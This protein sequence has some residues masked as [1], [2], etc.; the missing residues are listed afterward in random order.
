MVNR[1][2]YI[3]VIY[4]CMIGSACVA[5]S[6]DIT[7]ELPEALRFKDEIKKE[8]GLAV[9]R[10]EPFCLKVVVSGDQQVSGDVKI[11][12]IDKFRVR[13]H[14]TSSSVSMHNSSVVAKQV[15]TYHLIADKEGHY[16]LGP[17]KVVHNGSEYLSI[18]I[19]FRVL[20]KTKEH[21]EVQRQTK[22]AKKQGPEYEVFCEMDVDR[23]RVVI[24]EPIAVAV[25]IYSWGDVSGIEGMEFASSDAFAMK[26]I[27][28]LDTYKEMRDGKKFSVHKKRYF[29]IPN[30]IG[31]FSIDSAQIV[32]RVHQNMKQ[33]NPWNNHFFSSFFGG[34]ASRKIATSNAVDVTV[35]DLP[36]GGIAVDAVG[37]FR[38]FELKVDKNKVEINEPI[39]FTIEIEGRGNIDIV[40]APK[41]SLPGHI[42]TYESKTETQMVDDVLTGIRR[43]EF[44]MQV[45]KVG[46]VTIPK[47]ILN[48]F[49]IKTRSYQKLR[50]NSIKI[51]VMRLSNSLQESESKEDDIVKAK[52]ESREEDYHLS[53]LT[54]DINFILE[55]DAGAA[56][57]PCPFDIWIFLL[58]LLLVPALVYGE[59]FVK[60]F[61]LFKNRLGFSRRKSFNQFSRDFQ[62]LIHREEYQK[63]Y[64]FFIR[65]IAY[66][67]KKSPSSISE[68]FIERSFLVYGWKEEKTHEF[69]L[70]MSKCARCAFASS[71]ITEEERERLKSQ[72]LYWIVLIEKNN[73][74][75]IGGLQ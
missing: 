4:L 48:Y 37:E 24:G 40:S 19:T 20:N 55:E 22:M 46:V 54:Q 8:E 14:G 39:K 23:D 28:K 57:Y 6:V 51:D 47:Q 1:P 17:A 25:K 70:Y 72:G 34:G 67:C 10:N 9:F 52:D 36:K 21:E 73:D 53:N 27:E 33:D 64:D 32:Y 42:K 50:S 56:W 7:L 63:I 31:S 44:V 49:D 43:F 41:I 11:D 74:A 13:N 69:L 66:K 75:E 26:E 5:D 71:A 35:D 18:P 16:T 38:R 65:L 30:K 61:S 12:G 60:L 15:T 29:L 59:F 2:W 68:D 62:G 58:G 3:F 45:G